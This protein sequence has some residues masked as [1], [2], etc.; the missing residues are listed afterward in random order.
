[1][2]YEGLARIGKNGP[3]W[4]GVVRMVPEHLADP[5]RWKRPRRVFVNSMSDLF[6]EGLT[7]EE[8]AAVF[9][10]M[11]AAPKHTFQVL[12]KR[13]ARMRDWFRWIANQPTAT[14]APWISPNGVMRL[15]L[16]RIA[17]TVDGPWSVFSR[18]AKA[19]SIQWPLPNVWIGTSVEDQAT[20]DE[21]IPL[22]LETPAAIRWVSYEPALAELDLRPSWIAGYDYSGGFKVSATKLDW[23][24]CGGESGPGAR[25][26]DLA[27]AES[28][29]AQCKAAGMAVFVKQLGALAHDSVERLSLKDRKGGDWNEWPDGLKVREFPR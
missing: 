26:F 15:C 24:V 12:T 6:H 5:L 25:G 23:L 9:G 17:T 2:P 7:N 16:S 1:M 4:T 22:L 21:R 28:I 20:A 29:V 3:R 19:A 14:A 11:A 10:V 27:W 18:W 13:P 8:I